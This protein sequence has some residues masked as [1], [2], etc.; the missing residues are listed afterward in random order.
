MAASA[1]RGRGS[2]YQPG[3]HAATGRQPLGDKRCSIVGTSVFWT[4]RSVS[5][6]ARHSPGWTAPFKRSPNPNP[7]ARI[8][9]APFVAAIFRKRHS[10]WFGK[11]GSPSLFP[12][13]ICVKACALGSGDWLASESSKHGVPHASAAPQ[14]AS[15]ATWGLCRLKCFRGK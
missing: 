8:R 15:P 14:R 12:H 4:E 2:H 7:S 13:Q 3:K 11:S 1:Q 5:F 9:D 6:R 10:H